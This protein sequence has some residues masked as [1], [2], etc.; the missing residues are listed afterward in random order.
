MAGEKVTDRKTTAALALEFKKARLD[1]RREVSLTLRYDEL[2]IPRAYVADFKVEDCV[3]VE[4]KAE[5]ALTDRDRRQLQTYLKMDGAP[6]GLLLNFGAPLLTSAAGL[7]RVV[8][9][10]PHG[11]DGRK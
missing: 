4:L 1:F 9:N 11:S 10:F 3:V 6:L 7:R 2:V 8:N 5:S